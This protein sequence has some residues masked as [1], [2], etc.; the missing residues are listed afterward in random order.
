MTRVG[1]GLSS[2]RD[3]MSLATPGLSTHGQTWLFLRPCPSKGA[4][5][6]PSDGPVPTEPRQAGDGPGS[7]PCS[8]AHLAPASTCRPGSGQSLG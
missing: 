4:G 8:Q 2:M 5:V 7:W 1:G 6:W 3:S